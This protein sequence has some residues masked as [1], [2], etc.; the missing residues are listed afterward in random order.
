MEWDPAALLEK[1]SLK[2]ATQTKCKGTI[3]V[4]L[5]PCQYLDTARDI[6]FFNLPFCDAI[7]LRDFIRK[8]LTTQKLALIR[9]HPLKYP[10]M[11][12]GWHLPN[13]EMVRDF[14]KNTPWR[15]REEKS[16]IQAFHKIAWHLECPREEVEMFYTLIKVMKK[17][18]SLYRLLG[19]SVTVTKN[20]GSDALLGMRAKLAQAV[21]WHTSFQMSVN[22][23]PLRGMVNPD[24]PVELHRMEDEDGDPQE[25]VIT[26][27]REIMSKHKI[28]H[29]P[30]WQGIL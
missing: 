19:Y 15:S 14:M 9:R 17:N 30:L 8:A 28:N 16:T 7:G 6:I 27:V 24:K 12:W 2:M 1:T 25:S 3:L 13:F 5:K 10:Q 22:H 23:I 4:E 26:T 11:E 29:L 21:H 18:K 20:P